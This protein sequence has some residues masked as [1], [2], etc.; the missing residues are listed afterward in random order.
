MQALAKD[1]ARKA[2]QNTQQPNQNVTHE[3][4][5]R[6]CDRTQGYYPIF[7]NFVDL[8]FLHVT[9]CLQNLMAENYSETHILQ[10]MLNGK[11]VHL[12]Y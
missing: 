1:P 9:A 2:S 7:C 11:M 4:T 8:K 3:G 6:I 10:K 5:Q 12:Q